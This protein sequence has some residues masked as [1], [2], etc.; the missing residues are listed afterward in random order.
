MP[1]I[2]SWGLWIARNEVIFNDR[3]GS[4]MEIASKVVSIIAYF[5]NSVP[6]PRRGVMAQELINKEFPWG[7]FDGAARGFLLI[8]VGGLQSS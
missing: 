7:Y 3:H 8:V 1:F 4:P 2:I 5:L 6:A